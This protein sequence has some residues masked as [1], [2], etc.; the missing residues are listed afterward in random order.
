MFSTL[1]TWNN[2]NHG[3]H[4]TPKFLTW[5]R[6]CCQPGDCRR[7]GSRFWPGDNPVATFGP[8]NRRSVQSVL[9]SI[10]VFILVLYQEQVL[11]K[12]ISFCIFL[13]L[14]KGK[15]LAG[16]IEMSCLTL[17][18]AW[19]HDHFL[20][21]KKKH[22]SQNCQKT[23]PPTTS[24]PWANNGT[25]PPICA[26]IGRG[27]SRHVENEVQLATTAV[28]KIRGNA[29]VSCGTASFRSNLEWY[30]TCP[31]FMSNVDPGKC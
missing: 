9:T 12:G 2:S 5:S 26:V 30:S 16:W 11:Q 28:T 27:H 17:L 3:L 25:K 20:G 18:V 19:G 6:P 1:Q 8:P 31:N 21:R 23:S 4:L 15:G 24:A 22:H 7:V 13:L 14:I 10:C 29:T